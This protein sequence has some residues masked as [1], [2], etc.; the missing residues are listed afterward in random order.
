MR[1]NKSRG[2]G[3]GL[4]VPIIG[5]VLLAIGGLCYFAARWY[6]YLYGSQNFN[7][8][9]VTLLSGVEGVEGSI[10]VS[11][12]CEAVMM[13]LICTLGLTVW[14]CHRSRFHLRLNLRGKKVTLSPVRP[15][16]YLTASCL[17]CCL[18]IVQA[19]RI[20]GL[21]QWLADMGNASPLINQE[22]VSPQDTAITFPEQK[23]NLIYIYLESMETTFCSEEQGGSMETCVIPELYDLARENVSFSDTQDIGGWDNT[24]GANWT[25]GGIVAQVGGIPL[26]LPYGG[27][28]SDHMRRPLESVTL[29]WDI[30]KQEG[31][32]QAMMI[33]SGKEFSGRLNLMTGHGFDIIYDHSSAIQDGLVPEGY[34]VWWGIED[35]KLF[36]YARQE[37]TKIAAREEPFHFSLLTVDTHM[38][39]GYLCPDCPNTFSEQYENVYACS[40]AQVA[41]FVR[42]IQEQPF[43]ENTTV[44]LCGDHL[45]MDKGYFQR[46]NLEDARRRVYNCIINGA[47]QTE[48]TQNRVFTPMDMFPTTLAAM[49]CEIEG[50]RLGLGTNLYSDLPTLAE[51][52]GLEQL[53][54]ELNRSTLPYMFRFLLEPGQGQWIKKLF[55]DLVPQT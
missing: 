8:V 50:N 2:K 54:Q 38:P 19:I 36:D 17:I 27:N 22:Y 5:S 25:T 29:L 33:G 30:L 11:F 4:A 46:H 42:W 26:L 45:S 44:I 34:K 6:Q 53:D 51:R 49:G 39:D 3:R 48:N 37:L 20:V 9:L 15:G 41:A 12:V 55:P 14:C 31:Y 1:K 18:G 21:P 16:L 23:R 43:Y 35:S 10:I 52:M 40:S 13:T 32:Y 7:S 24:V 28:N 47:A